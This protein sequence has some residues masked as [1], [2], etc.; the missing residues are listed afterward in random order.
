MV[1]SVVDAAAGI[2]DRSSRVAVSSDSSLLS[3]M[4]GAVT[5]KSGPSLDFTPEQQLE[6]TVQAQN[7]T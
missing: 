1:A 5:E 7:T 2:R 3:L 4:R 6:K